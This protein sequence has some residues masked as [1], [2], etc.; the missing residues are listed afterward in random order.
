MPARS[1]MPFVLMYHS[2]APR[3]DDPY[4][5]TVSPW[6]FAEQMRWLR[7]Q[8]LRGVSVGAL[9]AACD[10]G[11]ATGLVGLTFDDGYADFDHHVAPV[12][13]RH[14]FG[15]TVFVVAGHLGGHNDWDRAG[16]RR[17]LLTAAQVRQVVARGFEV[18][19]HGLHHR[20]LDTEDT[21]LLR[22][23]MLTSKQVLEDLLGQRVPGFCYPYGAVN[24][25]A[26]LAA[27]AFGY[28]YAVATWPTGRRARHA[29]PRTYVGEAD[30]SV[31]LRAKR[32]RH[33][34][35]FGGAR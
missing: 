7:R 27:L 12:L 10:A 5:I 8:G 26:E 1:T 32:V 6:R 23:E 24:P 30:R 35:T 20:P 33:R 19:S 14:G 11:H 4:R 31:R 29:I 25:S 28:E 13:D 17:Q 22:A 15:A 9:L 16:R 3:D 34:L 2:V 18:G 21:E